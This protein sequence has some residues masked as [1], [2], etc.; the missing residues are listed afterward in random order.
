MGASVDALE[1]GLGRVR[2]VGHQEFDALRVN[3]LCASHVVLVGH[4]GELLG[5]AVPVEGLFGVGGLVLHNLVRHLDAPEAVLLARLHHLAELLIALGE[6]Q[7]VLHIHHAL[8]GILE[9]AEGGL[10]V[11]CRFHLVLLNKNI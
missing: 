8:G 5:Q 6:A 3:V 11:K 10:L 4:V 1:D 9:V 7:V 2:E